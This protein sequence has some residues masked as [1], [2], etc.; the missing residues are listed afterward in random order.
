MTELYPFSTPLGSPDE[1]LI[2]ERT[3][4]AEAVELIITVAGLTRRADDPT[5][6][7]R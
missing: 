4:H 1:T 3:S 7:V 2:P 6:A 5:H